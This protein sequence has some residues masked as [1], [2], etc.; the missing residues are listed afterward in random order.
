MNLLFALFF[1]LPS[2]A[3][4]RYKVIEKSDIDTILK[5]SKE[6]TFI[7]GVSKIESKIVNAANYIITNTK[8]SAR[9]FVIID[10]CAPFLNIAINNS[11]K[12]TIY[13]IKDVLAL[14]SYMYGY[15]DSQD[16][17]LLDEEDFEDFLMKFPFSIL[18]KRCYYQ[19]IHNITRRISEGNQF[20]NVAIVNDNTYD[21][22]FN[23]KAI[24]Y[25]KATNTTI[26]LN[27][28]TEISEIYNKSPK[29]ITY[30]ELM[31]DTRKTSIILFNTSETKQR[32]R[33]Y[34]YDIS[35]YSGRFKF[36]IM[37]EREK[38]LLET[39]IDTTN[40]TKT[41]YL[42]MTGGRGCYTFIDSFSINNYTTLNGLLTLNT[43]C[44]NHISEN[45]DQSKHYPIVQLNTDTYPQFLKDNDLPLILYY[46]DSGDAEALFSIKEAAKQTKKKIG[47]INIRKN[48]LN[49]TI[50]GSH[51]EPC[52]VI[53][54]SN[55][56]IVKMNKKMTPRNV[57]DFIYNTRVRM[58]DNFT[59]HSLSAFDIYNDAV[60]IEHYNNDDYTLMFKYNTY[61]SGDFKPIEEITQLNKKLDLFKN[62]SSYSQWGL[63]RSGMLQDSS[64][65][66]SKKADLT[67]FIAD[68]RAMQYYIA[69]FPPNHRNCIKEI[70]DDPTI[71]AWQTSNFKFI[72]T[73][74]G[75]KLIEDD[76]DDATESGYFR[77]GEDFVFSIDQSED[78]EDIE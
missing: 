74:D 64:I 42:M 59:T 35:N 50:P 60:N 73:A 67:A 58:S 5:E 41:T 33:D 14:E 6:L 19:E 23:A 37:Q 69:Y 44:Y 26:K 10:R 76:D 56:A 63:L 32:D 4:A 25:G 52:V 21:R 62:D 18:T 51:I 8:S 49:I 57:I 11:I 36:S 71:I 13:P 2:N 45:V 54:I 12:K 30:D 47:M 24:F 39:V 20:I 15:L 3:P 43:R 72:F 65:T 22:N 16:A 78:S 7:L 27:N 38:N 17:E 48:F 40:M 61:L 46:R 1:I 66:S 55:K 28:L 29:E 34:F 68:A 75:S 77:D 9:L 31:S 53:H 70:I